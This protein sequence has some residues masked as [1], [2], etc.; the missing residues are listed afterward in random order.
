MFKEMLQLLTKNGKKDVMLSA[1]FFVL[2]GL[3]SAAMIIIV[4]SVLFKI[5]SG[6]AAADVY[7]YF[8]VLVLLVVFKGVCN[9]SADIK[10]HGSGFDV[11][12]NIR[13]KMIVKLKLFGLGFYTDERLGEINTVLH[14]DVDNM[15]M[16]VGHM[17]PRMAS[18]FL[19]ALIC[20]IGLCV[21]NLRLALIM[22]ACIPVALG[23]LLFTIQRTQNAE[24]KNNCALADMVSLFVEYVRGIPVL[25]S[26][27]ENKKLDT[28]LSEKITAF[29]NTS[30]A[31][32]K[33]KACRLS[34][35]ALLLDIGYFILLGTGA[36]MTLRGSI[37]V[38]TYIIFAVL[39][40][41]FYKPFAEMETHYMY[42]VSASDSYARLGKILYAPPI[43]DNVKGPLPEHNGIEFC[44]VDFAYKKGK[45][46][47]FKI[48]N[49]NCEFA[50]HAMTA[51][52]GESGSG[53]TTVTNLLLRFYEV[54]KGSIR[55]GGKDIRNIPYDELLDR[56][57]IVM[58]NVQVFDDTI[59]ENIRVGK[60]NANKTEIIE[61]C[62][63]ARIHD[64]IQS[65]PDGYS[66]RV[67]ENGAL[68]SGGQRQRISIARAFLKNAPIL[69]LDE[70]T[71]NVDP[72][73][74]SLIQDA[75]TELAQNKTVI[76]IAH[77]LKTI[78]NADRIIVFKKGKAVEQGTHAELV[79]NNGYY[80]KLLSCVP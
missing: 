40:K 61:A 47:E 4:F 58:Q 57:G 11:V 19:I 44:S 18:D 17:L 10:K 28:E 78:R 75:L 69:I 80:A 32:S 55:L 6:A 66:S 67:G 72:L 1:L 76:I 46:D 16:V 26:F 54:D 2:Y 12:Q 25:K 51:L 33:F 5:A 29:G 23:F 31:A 43:A 60:K 36:I 62:K 8:I 53:K 50:E 13:E 7:R 49:L 30:K 42:Y 64:F 34:V 63:K 14:K 20:F 68:L 38:F 73:N 35:Y 27:S 41:E 56:I 74:E 59:E 65:L 71:S 3:S 45:K 79:Q 15:S 9:V 37:S 70:M 24:H 77:H 22:C 52:V 21:L 48:E 39:S